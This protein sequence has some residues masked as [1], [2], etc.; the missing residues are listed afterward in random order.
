MSLIDDK[1]IDMLNSETTSGRPDATI[2]KQTKQLADYIIE[3]GLKP[4]PLPAEFFYAS[5]P[6]CVID[7]VFSIGVTYTST[8]NTVT[9][10]CE[11]QGW[12]KSL[13]PDTP[14]TIGEHTINEFLAL[15]DGLTAEQM[16]DDLFGNRQRT[17]TRSGILKAEAVRQYAEALQANDIEDFGDMT[18]TSLT[19]IEK[20][21]RDIPGQGSGISFDYFRMLAGNDNL[22]KPDRMVQRYVAKATNMRSDRVTPEFAKSVLLSAIH[23]LAEQG[24]AWLPKK[25]DY[26]IWSFESGSQGI[27]S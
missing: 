6:L 21:V 4:L 15:F 10:F 26:T 27:V 7:A 13:V 16:A 5:L 9:R 25:L 18:E 3:T 12:A 17:S 22:I 11:R 19:M 24:Y 20:Q 23:V 8:A 1:E 14:R 2:E